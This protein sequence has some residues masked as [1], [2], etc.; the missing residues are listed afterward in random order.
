MKTV[1]INLYKF[2][3]LS[4]EAQ[5]IAIQEYKD[6]LLEYNPKYIG[7]E[8]AICNFCAAF[9]MDIDLKEFGLS[10]YPH[11]IYF[12]HTTDNLK[13]FSQGY[14]SI[15]QNLVE[16]HSFEQ[17]LWERFQQYQNFFANTKRLQETQLLDA[18]HKA[19]K[20]GLNY[21][22]QEIDN[23]SSDNNIIEILSFPDRHDFTIKGYYVNFDNGKY[24]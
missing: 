18:F 17:F 12:T 22:L 21:W 24:K 10:R 14:I 23:D 19:I 11:P 5:K 16:A 7:Y 6:S 9:Q 15:P 20:D 2:T 13:I 8:E 3:E 4:P 1:T